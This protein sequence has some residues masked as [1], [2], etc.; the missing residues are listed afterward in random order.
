MGIQANKGR[1]ANASSFGE[2][3]AQG[4]DLPCALMAESSRAPSLPSLLLHLP[5]QK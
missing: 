3:A 5:W 4:T 2:R 1:T